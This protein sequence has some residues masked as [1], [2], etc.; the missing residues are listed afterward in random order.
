MG[1]ASAMLYAGLAND[2]RPL[3]IVAIGI[4]VCSFGIGLGP[5]PFILASELV[6]AEA[7]GAAS[8]WALASNWLSTFLVAQFFP[9]LNAAL[10]GGKVWWLFTAIAAVFTVFVAIFV[11]E[12]KGKANPDE[13]WGGVRRS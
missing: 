2:M 11:P 3:T 5:V 12:S 1:A 8:S 4:F 7:V 13:V 10:P 9:M 6:G